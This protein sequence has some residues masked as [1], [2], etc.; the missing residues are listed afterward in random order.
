MDETVGVNNYGRCGWDCFTI[1]LWTGRGKKFL[2][3]G[4]EDLMRYAKVYDIPF[5]VPFFIIYINLAP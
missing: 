3:Q 4:V 5:V 1:G 2:L